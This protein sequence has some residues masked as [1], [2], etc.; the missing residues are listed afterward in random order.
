[1]DMVDLLATDAPMSYILNYTLSNEPDDKEQASCIMDIL[2]MKLKNVTYTYDIEFERTI[3]TIAIMWRTLNGGGTCPYYYCK[4]HQF[5]DES[6][7][8]HT[9]EIFTR[10]TNQIRTQYPE[11]GK[12]WRITYLVTKVLKADTMKQLKIVTPHCPP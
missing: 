2:R 5:S 11:F 8:T 12:E 4:P 3:Y 10:L 1:M 9:E 7:Q 6:V